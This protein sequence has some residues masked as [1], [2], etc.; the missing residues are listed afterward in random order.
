[1]RKREFQLTAPEIRA[2][3]AR[4]SQT[5]EVRELKRLQGVR[6]YGMGEPI[7]SIQGVVGCAESTLREWV[8]HYERGGLAGLASGYERSA[9]NAR[10]LSD[11]QVADLRQRLHENRPETVLGKEA[12]QFWTV[13]TLQVVI[14]RWYGVRFRDGR[15]YRE[16]LHQCGFSYQRPEQVYKSRPHE[17]T[18]AAFENDLEKK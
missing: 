3:G 17:V 11:E 4:E 1:M 13:W 9:R 2:F 7:S 12:G 6:L 5:R 14:E 15:S 10:K 18:L 8:R 16:L